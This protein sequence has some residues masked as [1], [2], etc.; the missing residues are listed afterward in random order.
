MLSFFVT[1]IT[2]LRLSDVL[3]LDCWVRFCGEMGFE[4]SIGSRPSSED[5]HGKL[6]A[7]T[8]TARWMLEWRMSFKHTHKILRLNPFTINF[9]IV[10]KV[11][12]PMERRTKVRSR[13]WTKGAIRTQSLPKNLLNC[14]QGRSV[15]D[16]RSSNFD[17][18]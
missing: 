12:R 15:L 8:E 17:A 6:Y 11:G 16:R 4:M 5:S 1:V 3:I 18:I 7:K 9:T 14:S 2:F 10:S 13:I